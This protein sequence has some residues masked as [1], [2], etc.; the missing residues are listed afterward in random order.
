MTGFEAVV[1]KLR[2]SSVQIVNRAGGGSGIV[3]DTE[4]RIVTNAHVVRG[5]SVNAI[6]ANGR[7]HP[8]KLIRHDPE[9]DLALL[10]TGAAL[11]PAE[12]GDSDTL[13]A[14]HFAIAIG[15]PLGVTGAVAAGTIH[16]H[17]PGRWIEADIRLAPGNSGGILADVRGRVIGINTMIFNGLGLAIPSNEAAAFV[18]GE[19]SRTR[20]G[21]EMLPVREGLLVI[22]IEKSSRAETV[23]I[24][25]GDIIRCTPDQL[26]NLI[27]SRADLPILRA[28]RTIAIPTITTEACAA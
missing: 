2:R 8:A 26:R 6:D 9:R 24:R 10:E 4:G 3:W 16:S 19:T 15:N 12:I 20:L 1:E 18:N 23:G 22:K 7:S 21:I 14:G 17:A 11:E 5:H 28:G 25:I 27:A 13:R